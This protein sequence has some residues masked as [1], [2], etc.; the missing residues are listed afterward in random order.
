MEDGIIT[1]SNPNTASSEGKPIEGTLYVSA[2]KWYCLRTMPNGSCGISQ[3]PLT[4]LD[5]S[6]KQFL[7][8]D[9]MTPAAMAA[10][11]LRLN[12]K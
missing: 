5:S 2:W 9:A 1:E 7:Q 11:M 6:I 3:F 4:S 8:Q 10:R 12:H